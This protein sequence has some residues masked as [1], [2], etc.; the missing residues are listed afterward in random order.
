MYHFQ[1][2]RSS[3]RNLFTLSLVLLYAVLFNLLLHTYST[4]EH[5]SG[6]AA[7][8]PRRGARVSA[9]G[10]PFGALSGGS[11]EREVE[12]NQRRKPGVGNRYIQKIN[13]RTCIIV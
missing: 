12:A 11:S 13:A 6:R 8:V 10:Q 7:H 1:D 5:S 9:P 3:S 2:F 4:L